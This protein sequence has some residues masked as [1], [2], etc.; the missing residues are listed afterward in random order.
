MKKLF[1]LLSVVLCVLSVGKT[2]AQISSAGCAQD[3]VYRWVNGAKV[4]L[5]DDERANGVQLSCNHKKDTL[6][7]SVFAWGD[8]EAGYVLEELEYD[9]VRGTVAGNPVNYDLSSYEKAN[10]ASL[11]GDDHWGQLFSFSYRN[12]S[13]A[14]IP[15][16]TF[17]FFGENYNKC[18]PNT[19]GSL[20]LPR[21]A[22]D[23]T[24]RPNAGWCD[25]STSQP[26][27]DNRTTWGSNG[28]PVYNAVICLFQDIYFN[29]GSSFQGHLYFMVEG[30]YPCR[31]VIL[32]YYQIPVFGHTSEPEPGIA[33]HMAILY[34]T[35]NVIEFYIKHSGVASSTNHG[36]RICGI[37]NYDLQYVVVPGMNNTDT[38]VDYKAYRIRPTG[39]LDY[40]LHW[41]KRPSQGPN[42]GQE[43]A[44]TDYV[45]NDKIEAN[46]TMEEG[47][48]TYIAKAEIWRLDNN[49]FF[50]YDSVTYIPF[51]V[52]PMVLE[53]PRARAE[54][55]TDSKTE[56]QLYDTVCK[57]ETISFTLKGADKYFVS[58]P[59]S[60]SNVTINTEQV[61]VDG[62]TSTVGHVTILNSPGQEDVQYVFEYRNVADYNENDILCQRFLACNIHNRS[63]TIDIGEDQTICRNQSVTY[64]DNTRPADAT[65]GVYTWSTGFT[66]DE[67]TYQPQATSTL[68]CTLTDNLGCTATD[69]ALI[70]VNDAPD[71]TI[72]GTMSICAGT[73][74][75]LTAQ[76][77]LPGCLYE[78]SNGETTET[79]T[80]NP[81]ATTTYSVSVKLPPAMCETIAEATVTVKQQPDIFCSEDKNIC[82]GESA[83]ISVSTSETAP[84]RYVWESSDPTVNGSANTAFTV[85]PSYTTQYNVTAYND[86]DCHSSAS[87]TVFVE[88]NPIPI[89][90][91]NPRTIDAL[92]PIV[93]FIDS[94]QNS[95]TT[96]WQISD[97][98]SSEDRTFVHEFELSDTSL[99]YNVSLT[100]STAFGCTSTAETII[101]VKR[102]HYLWAP[103]G[104]YLHANDP[105]NATFRL[106]IDNITEYSLKIFNRWGT[107]VFETDDINQ[108]W[109][110]TYKGKTVEQGV[111]VWKATFRHNDAPN[112][113]QKDSGEFMIY[114]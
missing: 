88:Q 34:E 65:D 12:P 73:S 112:R 40:D 32:S 5:T 82:N 81:A 75:T 92:T 36:N 113:L 52:D 38:Q 55:F 54:S 57:G 37:Q 63:F 10:E 3:S 48:T 107:L 39:A 98:A 70:N 50:V 53:T 43:I 69:E 74:T 80:V 64:S 26:L 103:T 90:T 6:F 94:T 110:G 114:E 109:D 29:S 72:V 101:R 61:T 15:D 8:P 30:E 2:K 79:I 76:S 27:P 51:D 18:I 11:S 1:W 108:A 31:K 67:I 44:I 45:G 66:G 22:A 95:A 14:G 20:C 96:L 106:Y 17:N 86:I 93:V 4:Q 23:E 83:E 100:S 87:V 78:W 42:A 84:L 21:T 97:G 58:E 46:P 111:Y 102:Q 47:P 91:F 56:I 99:S 71:V 60:A 77:S 19:N 85:V 68:T 62:V 59:E 7:G 28:S 16:F 105:A 104:M 13:P 33:T 41:F 49:S 89:I 9:S 35:T 24:A 25:Y